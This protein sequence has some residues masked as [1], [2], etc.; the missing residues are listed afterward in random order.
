[1]DTE[2]Q[3]N[4]RNNREFDSISKEIEFQE[5]EIQ[6]SEK[7]ISEAKANIEHKAE[8]LDAAKT[9]L[10]ERQK[11]LDIKKNELKEISAGTEKDE[12]KLIKESEKAKKAIEDRLVVAYER[13]RNNSRNGLAVVPVERD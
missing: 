6:L 2:Q 8:V 7:K 9:K 1:M 5:L 3:K 10:D 11:D 13:L 12:Q 4:V